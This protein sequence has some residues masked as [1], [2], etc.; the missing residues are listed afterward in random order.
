MVGFTSAKAI[1]GEGDT[2]RL[3]GLG[4]CGDLPL[5]LLGATDLRSPVETDGGTGDEVGLG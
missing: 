5:L 4:P 2:L 1:E 3:Y